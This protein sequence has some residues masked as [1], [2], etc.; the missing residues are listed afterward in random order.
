MSNTD[1]V[2]STLKTWIIISAAIVIPSICIDLIVSICPIN[3][4]LGAIAGALP[5]AALVKYLSIQVNKRILSNDVNFKFDD[6]RFADVT[7]IDTL[8][9]ADNIGRIENNSDVLR[10]KAEANRR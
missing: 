1:A 2:F 9:P 10:A 3:V 6:R 4:I 5:F 7:L 8:F